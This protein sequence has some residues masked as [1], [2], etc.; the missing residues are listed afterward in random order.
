LIE[1]AMPCGLDSVQ[2][3]IGHGMPG[4]AFCDSRFEQLFQVWTQIFDDCNT[5]QM[6]GIAQRSNALR[7]AFAGKCFCDVAPRQYSGLARCVL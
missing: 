1:E 2:S 5:D 4:V 3:G 6:P 7:W